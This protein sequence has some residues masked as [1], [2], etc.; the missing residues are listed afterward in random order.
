MAIQI[1]GPREPLDFVTCPACAHSYARSFVGPSL[2]C[3]VSH[4]TWDWDADRLE[5]DIWGIRRDHL[6]KPE[7]TVLL[8][9]T[10]LTFESCAMAKQAL[11]DLEWIANARLRALE[12]G[13]TKLSRQERRK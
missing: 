3:P 12:R 8:D 6:P 13:L 2:K 10:R 5:K 9:G 1:I 4:C 11:K 7:R